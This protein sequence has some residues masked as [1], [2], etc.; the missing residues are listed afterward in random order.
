MNES[1]IMGIP[2]DEYKSQINNLIAS[3]AFK[4]KIKN[5]D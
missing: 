1:E 5:R 2:K 4:Y 3:A